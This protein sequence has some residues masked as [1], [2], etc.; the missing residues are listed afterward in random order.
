MVA[1]L[2]ELMSRHASSI[3]VQVGHH[4]YARRSCVTTSL[5]LSELAAAWLPRLPMSLVAFEA[6]LLLLPTRR[7]RASA[8]CESCLR[9]EERDSQMYSM[10][11]IYSTL[12][13]SI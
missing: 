11:A 12:H 10:V 5:L 13:I 6:M 2:H 1:Q 8:I 9:R 7:F 4:F 3:S